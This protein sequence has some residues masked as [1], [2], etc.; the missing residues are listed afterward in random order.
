MHKL[1]AKGT[2]TAHNSKT[3]SSILNSLPVSEATAADHTSSSVRSHVQ[4]EQLEVRDPRSFVRSDQYN[5][6]T[7]MRSYQFV[8]RVLPLRPIK[9]HRPLQPNMSPTSRYILRRLTERRPEK[10]CVKPIP[11]VR[12][13]D[14]SPYNAEKHSRFR[15]GGVRKIEKARVRTVVLPYPPRYRKR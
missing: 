8:D 13:Y 1:T 3:G 6:R 10:T 11:L 12:T 15:K 2:R 5:K 7:R 14:A 9:S 4:A